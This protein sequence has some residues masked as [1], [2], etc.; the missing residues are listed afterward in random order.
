MSNFF[1][2]PFPYKPGELVGYYIFLNP[3]VDANTGF[4]GAGYMEFGAWGVVLNGVAVGLILKLFD[5]VTPIGLPMWFFGTTAC[6]PFM[7]LLVAQNVN[8]SIL[9]AGIVVL[10]ALMLGSRQ[11]DLS[12]RRAI[13]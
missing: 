8:T 9:S 4:F 1:N 11:F 6:L 3:I 7:A 13:P 10:F 2:Y 5:R 12:E